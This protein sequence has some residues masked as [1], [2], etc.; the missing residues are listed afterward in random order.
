MAMPSTPDQVKDRI[1]KLLREIDADSVSSAERNAESKKALDWIIA[2]TRRPQQLYRLRSL[3]R[4][5]AQ[6]LFDPTLATKAMV[7]LSNLGTPAGQKALVNVASTDA[8]DIKLRRA[9]AVSFRYS[10]QRFGL[11]LKTSEILEQY[12]RYNLSEQ[13][14]LATQ[15]VMSSLL[16]AIERKSP[17]AK[18]DEPDKPSEKARAG[19]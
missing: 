4:Q 2:I 3:D 19:N 7:A 18:Q 8:L 17:P 9:A 14:D 15:R 6:A 10:V 1:R 13:K 11:L 16:N 12:E 5:V